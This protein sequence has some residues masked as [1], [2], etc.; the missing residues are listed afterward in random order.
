MRT[1]KKLVFTVDK[2]YDYK[3]VSGQEIERVKELVSAELLEVANHFDGPCR[4][5]MFISAKGNA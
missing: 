3:P 4:I 1:H 5:K 2:P